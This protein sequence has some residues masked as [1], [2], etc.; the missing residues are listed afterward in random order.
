MQKL[1]QERGGECLSTVY[2]N[3]FKMLRWRCAEGHEWEAT[4]TNIKNN[5]S[6]CR[7]CAGTAPRTVE[8][9]QKVAISHGGEF[10]SDKYA[11]V[12]LKFQAI[13]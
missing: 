12:P 10:L 4:G 6:W 8:D 5:N 9:M 3:S 2:E 7:E 13:S 11:F 1:A